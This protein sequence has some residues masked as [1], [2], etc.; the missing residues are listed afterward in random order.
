MDIKDSDFQKVVVDDPDS[1]HN[2][3]IL[4]LDSISAHIVRRVKECETHINDIQLE[5]DAQSPT[6]LNENGDQKSNILGSH[7]DQCVNVLRDLGL[8]S[9]D[10]WGLEMKAPQSHSVDIETWFPDNYESPCTSPILSPISYMSS[11]KNAFESSDDGDANS[12][13]DYDDGDYNDEGDANNYDDYFNW[14]HEKTSP[15]SSNGSNSIFEM[16]SG[17]QDFKTQVLGGINKKYLKRSLLYLCRINAA[18]GETYKYIIGFTRDLENVLE[19]IDDTYACEWK[20]EI[21]TLSDSKSQNEEVKTKYELLQKNVNIDNNLYD[22]NNHV[23]NHMV[24]NA[25]YVNPFY[26][27]DGDGNETYLGKKVAITKHT[28]EH[29]E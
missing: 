14:E 17:I 24:L 20:I 15:R 23:Y 13:G 5:V 25:A 6:S 1:S 8:E 18:Q 19:T 12:D 29:I 26:T 9:S 4:S 21:L 2:V 22:V 27:V 3:R 28:S 10:I 11:Y 7:Q 16:L